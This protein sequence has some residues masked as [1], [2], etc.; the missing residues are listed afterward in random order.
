[1]N[2]IITIAVWVVTV[3]TAHGLPMLAWWLRVRWQIQQ[4]NAR[5]QHLVTIVHTLPRGGQIVEERSDGTW[6]RLGVGRSPAE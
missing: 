3:I 1:M 4:E 5:L 2:P 6:L